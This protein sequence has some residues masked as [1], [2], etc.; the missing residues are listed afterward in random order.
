VTRNGGF[1]R[2]VSGNSL[3]E[4]EGLGT[5]RWAGGK[6]GE[7]PWN[8]SRCA[9]RDGRLVGMAGLALWF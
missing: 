3:T 8:L 1:E 4:Y 7:L 9:S 5:N 2:R 6:E